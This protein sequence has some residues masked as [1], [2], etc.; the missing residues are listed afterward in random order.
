MIVIMASSRLSP[1]I[2]TDRCGAA[3]IVAKAGYVTEYDEDQLR[4]VLLKVFSTESLR[5][6]L[7]D[8]GKKLVTEEFR[9]DV[10]VG[11]LENIYERTRNRR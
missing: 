10:I 9:W 3:E 2:V 6:R 4:D 5:K 7:G 11:K 1:V 8:E